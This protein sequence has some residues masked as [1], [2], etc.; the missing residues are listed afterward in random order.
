MRRVAIAAS[1]MLVVSA[2]PSFAQAG[3]AP[4]A[5]AQTAKPAPAPAQTAPPPQPAPVLPSAPFIA[6][7][8]VGLVNLQAI[9][10]LSADGKTASGRV[11]AL[12]QKKQSEGAEKA[13]QLAANQ[14]KLETGGGVMTDAARAALEKE[15]DRQTR[16]GERFQQDAQ[17]EVA[18]L[19]QE[20][21]DEFQKKLFPLLEAIA[22]EKGLQMLVSQQD[23]GVIWWDQ[24]IDLTADAVKRLDAATAKPK[25]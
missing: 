9:A 4:A 25:E 24:G 19:Q 3:S 22:K 23:A 14:Q 6:G 15:I 5:P 12:I 17:A 2:A 11:N 20:L 16:E 8:K 1:L 10:Q 13:K 21:Q 18:E 7:A